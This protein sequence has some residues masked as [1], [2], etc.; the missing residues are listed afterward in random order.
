MHKVKM[1]VTTAVVFAV[2]LA[3]VGTGAEKPAGAGTGNQRVEHGVIT[4]ASL[5]ADMTD[6]AALA[7]FP[8]P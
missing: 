5:L 4:M 1:S 6:R 8:A 3:M 2:G 7:G